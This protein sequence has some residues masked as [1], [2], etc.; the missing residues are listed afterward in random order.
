MEK[1]GKKENLEDLPSTTA[2]LEDSSI[3]MAPETNPI[4]TNFIHDTVNEQITL[5]QGHHTEL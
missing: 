5:K 3:F 2:D 4:G 1:K